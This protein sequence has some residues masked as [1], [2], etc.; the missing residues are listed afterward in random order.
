MSAT[1]LPQGCPLAGKSDADV[2]TLAHIMACDACAETWPQIAR[3]MRAARGAALPSDDPKFIGSN[4]GYK[5]K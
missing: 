5:D 1:T 4:V 2:R 3:E